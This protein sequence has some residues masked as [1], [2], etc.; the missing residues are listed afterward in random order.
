MKKIKLY[1][2]ASLDGYIARPDGDLDWLT[3][4]P[5][6]EK[7]DFGYNTFLESVDTTLM[8]NE[9]YKWLLNEG[10]EDP[11][12]GLKN[13]V[14]TRTKKE[15]NGFVEFVTDNPASFVKTIREGE[16]KDVFLVGGGGIV[17]PLLAA[18]LI[19]EI[20]LII[21]PVFLGRGIPLFPAQMK[22]L[23][24]LFN[25]VDVVKHSNGF[26]SIKMEKPQ[27]KES[28]RKGR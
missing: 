6:P 5:N 2:A 11:Y 19:D 24:I 14:F 13:Y 26:V 9:T 23:N 4:A 17:S 15:S 25:T 8:G 12:P 1:I 10:V 18:E 22:D 16:G 7:D 28:N 27:R 3:K 21:V 20:H